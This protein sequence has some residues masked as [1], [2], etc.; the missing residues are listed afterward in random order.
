[1]SFAAVF[2]VA[3]AHPDW[4]V[5]SI[6]IGTRVIGKAS[7]ERVVVIVWTPPPGIVNEMVVLV[8]EA[9][10]FACW[11]AARRVQTLRAVLQNPSLV[12]ASSSSAVLVTTYGPAAWTAAGP[13][14]PASNV[15]RNTATTTC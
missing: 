7:G 13:I 3:A 6:V 11:I 4:V 2:A 1:M 9:S 10:A 12:S 14:V 15:A 5:P 8:G